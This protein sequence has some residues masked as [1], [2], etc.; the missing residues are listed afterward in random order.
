MI[1]F[2]V[3]DLPYRVTAYVKQE[4]GNVSICHIIEAPMV[5]PR[6]QYGNTDSGISGLFDRLTKTK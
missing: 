2:Q 3:I 6:K 1:V 4:A 5:K